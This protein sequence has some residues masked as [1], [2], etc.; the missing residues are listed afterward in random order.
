MSALPAA[1]LPTEAELEFDRQVDALATTGLPALLD[2]K[3]TCFRAWLEPLRDQLPADDGGSTGVP[4]VVV[5]PDLPVVDVLGA[6]HTLGGSGFTTMDAA[7]LA[8]F[9]PLPEIDVPSGPYLLLDVDTGPET[10]DQT[11][12]DVLPRITGAGRSPLTVAEGLSV[13]VS[14]PGVLRA[15]NCFSLAGS[16]CGDKRV[17][18]LWVSARRPRL[19]WCY[20]GAPHTWLGTASCAGRRGAA[21]L[22]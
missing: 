3:E 5:L 17:P 15:R 22:G 2:L 12:A 7:D 14:D 9:R 6:V 11:P 21:P 8:R 1:R 16:R 13:L 18:A 19:G 10:L 20:Q 4:F